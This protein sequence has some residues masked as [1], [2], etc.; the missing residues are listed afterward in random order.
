MKIGCSTSAPYITRD[1]LR[2]ALRVAAAAT[3]RYENTEH[4]AAAIALFQRIEQATL[5]QE[6]LDAAKTRAQ[7]LLTFR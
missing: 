6:S 2:R 1:R 4:E 7:K 3:R 5:Q